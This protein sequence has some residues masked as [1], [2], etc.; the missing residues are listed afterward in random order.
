MREHDAWQELSAYF[1]FDQGGSCFCFLVVCFS[2]PIRPSDVDGFDVTTVCVCDG[3]TQDDDLN[4]LADG[5]SLW[6]SV[7]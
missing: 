2:R 1:R 7:R 4:A 5:A 3:D 6:S